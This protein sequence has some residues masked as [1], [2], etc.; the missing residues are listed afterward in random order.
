[1]VLLENGCTP[2]T[3]KIQATIVPVPATP[4]FVLK[5]DSLI[6]Y[7]SSGNQWLLNGK[8]ISGAN[9]KVYHI[10]EN[11]KYSLINLGTAG[12]QSDTSAELNFTTTGISGVKN[13]VNYRAYPNP[14]NQTLTL[15]AE[16]EFSYQLIDL[17]GRLI[18]AAKASNQT[19]V[20]CSSFQSG[21]YQLIITQNGNS[22]IQRIVK[23][24]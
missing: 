1:M 16:G 7:A 6:S 21:V 15:E 5:F 20:V 3:Y 12:C 23:T 19:Q 9:D 17:T 11:G 18:L 14:V 8:P 4:T 24:Q 2:T 22:S 13:E 10:K